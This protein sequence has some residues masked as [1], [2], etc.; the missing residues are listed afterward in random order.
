MQQ[1]MRACLPTACFTASTNFAGKDGNKSLGINIE[2]L[3]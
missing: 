3:Q 1:Y 2:R